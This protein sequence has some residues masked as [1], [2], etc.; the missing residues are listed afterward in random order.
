MSPPTS[1]YRLRRAVAGLAVLPALSRGALARTYAAYEVVS[2]QRAGLQVWLPRGLPP[3]LGVGPLQVLGVGDGSVDAPLAA[4]G[5]G[6]STPGSSRP[7]RR[8]PDSRPGSPR[9]TPILS[10]SPPWPVRSAD[11]EATVA[12]DLVHFVHSLYHYRA[13]FL[14]SDP[15]RRVA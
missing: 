13:G 15:N 8:R 7:Q 3:L 9:W 10:L 1:L 2:D 14:I 11:R 5:R 6:G 4:D 12:A